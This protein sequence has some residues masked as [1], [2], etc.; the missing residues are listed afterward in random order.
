MDRLIEKSVLTIGNFDGVHLGHR[1]LINAVIKEARKNKQN[2]V[3]YTFSPHPV[4]FLFPER[5]HH[6]LVSRE[7]SFEIIKGMVDRLI[8]KSFDLDFSKLSP[9][10]FIEECIVKPFNPSLIIVGDNFRFGAQGLGSSK[11]L[12]ELGEK[13]GFRLRLFPSVKREGRVLSSSFVKETILSG[14]WPLV[15]QL[16]E[17]AFSIRGLIVKG[18]GRG[19]R[20][21]FPTLNLRI[22]KNILIPSDG[23]YVVRVIGKDKYFQGVANI[24]LN[25]TFPGNCTKKIEIHLLKHSEKYREKSLELEFL[26]YLRAEKKFSRT[27][28]LQLQ[29][30]QDISKAQ[31]YFRLSP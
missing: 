6:L 17:R 30:K 26:G 31:E 1:R 18:E 20:M 7:Q 8:V 3:V 15:S 27:E 2:S 13:H 5:K 22:D 25:P 14:N 19:K 28:D 23:V 4:Q 16:L 21:G 24:G 12:Q 29:I 9:Q 10:K 11:T